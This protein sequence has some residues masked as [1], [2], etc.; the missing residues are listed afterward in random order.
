M[1]RIR[2]GGPDHNRADASRQD[3]IDTGRRQ[4]M[5][6]AGLERDVQHSIHR[7]M[8]TEGSQALAKLRFSGEVAAA[9]VDEAIRL[10][11][12]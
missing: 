12:S 3:G 5:G 1:A 6:A 8:P 2:I 11:N 7:W 10:M 4:A 9:D